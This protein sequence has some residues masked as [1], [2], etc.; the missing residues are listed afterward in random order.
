MNWSITSWEVFSEVV[1]AKWRNLDVEREVAE[2]IRKMKYR[3]GIQSYVFNIM[4]LNEDAE[5][6]SLTFQT[7]ILEGLL[8]EIRER[9]LYFC[10]PVD[11]EQ[12]IEFL[13]QAGKGYKAFIRSE[14]HFTWHS[15][16]S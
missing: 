6:K 11:G 8:K 9:I 14:K 15:G 16:G 10:E 1:V 7:S 5:M 4:N 13:E 12:F 3:G 2:K